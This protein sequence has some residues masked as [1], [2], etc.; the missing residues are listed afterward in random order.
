MAGVL[1]QVDTCDAD[2]L[3]ELREDPRV[4]TAGVRALERVNAH[5]PGRAGPQ[6]KIVTLEDLQPLVAAV[7]KAGRG[8][9][10]ATTFHRRSFELI[11]ELFHQSFGPGEVE[12]DIDEGRKRLDAR[13][14]NVAEVGF[15]KWLRSGG[16]G[17]S[18]LGE[19]KNYSSDVANAELDQLTGRFAP[20]RSHV[21]LLVC[22]GFKNKKLFFDRCRDAYQAGRGLVI[23]LDD[24]DLE[25]LAEI[26]TDA[27]WEA[28]GTWLR[29][30]MKPIMA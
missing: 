20:W 18:V 30:H 25:S 22:R 15:F 21:G 5:L 2:A 11:G 7:K 27:A 1:Q 3:L 9:R 12:A 8:R 23:P 17:P 13:W 10:A 26:G 24:G 29:D 28:Q 16:T 6:L 14:P 4:V 19:M